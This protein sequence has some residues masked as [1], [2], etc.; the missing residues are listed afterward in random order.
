MFGKKVIIYL[1]VIVADALSRNNDNM[2]L[3]SAVS[4][5]HLDFILLPRNFLKYNIVINN[6]IRRNCALGCCEFSKKPREVVMRVHI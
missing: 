5:T 6:Y 1:L 3:S 2:Q 4:A